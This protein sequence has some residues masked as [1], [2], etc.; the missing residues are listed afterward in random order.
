MLKRICISSGAVWEDKVG[1]SRAVRVGNIIEVSGTTA[2]EGEKVIGKGDPFLQT[3][4]IIEK[5][6]AALLKAGSSLEDVTMVRIYVTDIN[7][8]EEIGKALSEYFQKIKPA[9]TLVQ[10]SALIDPDL[11]VEIEAKAIT[12]DN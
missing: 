8:W 12:S 2:I 9:A 11:L 6:K 10:V 3:K 5:I 7:N 4:T 1:Y